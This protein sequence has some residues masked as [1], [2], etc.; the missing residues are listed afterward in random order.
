[1]NERIIKP[2]T[3]ILLYIGLSTVYWTWVGY[4]FIMKSKLKTFLLELSAH[5]QGKGNSYYILNLPLNEQR[6]YIT[7]RE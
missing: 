2:E 1:M 5:N 4:L 7:R 3:H 6:N